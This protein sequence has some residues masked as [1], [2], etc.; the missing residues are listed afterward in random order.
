M[1]RPS[2]EDG[3][4][5]A[6][7]FKTLSAIWSGE[8]PAAFAIS[9]AVPAALSL[10]LGILTVLGGIIWQ[11]PWPIAVVGG[12]GVL[13]LVAVGCAPEQRWLC[14]SFP[15]GVAMTALHVWAPWQTYMDCLP[16]PE[17]AG[18]IRACV[19]RSEHVAP[20]LAWLSVAPRATV[21][22]SAFRWS[23]EAEWT[24][25]SG[26]VLLRLASGEMPPPYGTVIEAEGTFVTPPG[27]LFPGAFDYQ[28]YLWTQGIRHVF[29]V[30]GVR[31][32]G[33]AQGWRRAMVV[34]YQWRDVLGHALVRRGLSEE[35][36]RTVLALT[37]GY[38]QGVD[39]RTR[40]RLLRS[41]TVH[42]FAIS[43]LHVGMVCALVV[44]TLRIL[45]VP[46][47]IR[48]GIVPLFLGVYVL[49]TGGRPSAVRAWLMLS[50]WA[51]SKALYRPPVPLNA[52]A[53]AGWLLLVYRPL[54]LLQMG[55][56]FSFIIVVALLAMWP[57]LAS[58]LAWVSERGRWIPRRS[59]KLWG[60]GL[61]PGRRIVQMG[62]ASLVAWLASTGLVAW[63]NGLFIPGAVLVNTA[64]AALAFLGILLVWPKLLLGLLPFSAA[65]V[66]VGRV[67]EV[68]VR[69]VGVLADLGAKE[70]L[71][72]AVGRPARSLVI[73]Y[74][75]SLALL[76][77]WPGSKRLRM[78]WGGIAGLALVL[79]VSG[80]RGWEPK[81]VVF[82]GG[83]GGSPGLVLADSPEIPPLV[84]NTGG[85]SGARGMIS[86]FGLNGHGQIEQV[87]V[88]GDEWGE[89]GGA[90]QL[91]D[92][93]PVRTLALPA[94][95]GND[96]LRA[97]A[98]HHFA[99]G[100]R[101]RFFS[102]DDD[103][104]AVE[105]EHLGTNLSVTSRS[106][107]RSGD[108]RIC[109]YFAGGASTVACRHSRTGET[110]VVWERGGDT[111]EWRVGALWHPTV[112][113]LRLPQQS[114]GSGEHSAR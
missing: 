16:R 44:W 23:P 19:T 58:M 72:L 100:G 97:L 10:V 105:Q 111:R 6:R 5:L 75:A 54:S 53:V 37:L 59:G 40:A 108:M 30:S 20:E 22:I 92:G 11:L 32:T 101:L 84:I 36:R 15:L 80:P 104:T 21:R 63:Y 45:R 25:C 93:M 96:T 78:L 99:N 57:H 81:L 43:G 79:I 98:G 4:A 107:R 39:T 71:S 7:F 47:R 2:G 74:Y 77:F 88:T 28:R 110:V 13:L 17:C 18:E 85:R 24:S 35:A 65:D 109:R 9:P 73:L 61:L 83:G 26:R 86:W 68:V 31:R 90:A 29:L 3:A 60:D 76:F 103:G 48:W 89:C 34:M 51:T 70:P 1:N 27:A 56:Q 112:R 46:F 113:V 50:V 106:W 8:R 114:S 82:A 62:L 102:Q 64:V 67:L 69:A 52:V 95:A 49:M 87:V 66:F 91:L 38:R 12:V 94:D 55:V 33:P 14:A 42:L 41:G